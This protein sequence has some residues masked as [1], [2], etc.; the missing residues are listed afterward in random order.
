MELVPS[1]AVLSDQT[2]EWLAALAASGARE[3]LA[4]EIWHTALGAHKRH[5]YRTAIILAMN[6]VEVGLKQFIGASIPQAEWFVLN[7][8]MPPMTK[9]LRD[10][11]PTL[12]GVDPTQL[13]DPKIRKV[14]TDAVERRNAF[15]HV[16]VKFSDPKPLPDKNESL[17]VLGA[18]SDL[19]WLLDYYSG[20]DMTG[21]SADWGG[22]KGSHWTTGLDRPR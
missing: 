21:P 13:P 8:Q 22:Q 17:K 12:P 2:E 19:L 10:F 1:P 11:L 15:I 7:A 16:G 20:N 14:L 3:P 6:A 5:E 18:A 9:V 4:R